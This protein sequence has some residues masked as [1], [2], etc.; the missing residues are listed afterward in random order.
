MNILITGGTGLIGSAL[1]D[2]WHLQHQLIVLTRSVAKATHLAQKVQLVASL[3][4]VDFNQLD[5]VI[6]LAGEP[7]VGKRWS[8]PQKRQLCD[9]RWLLT[10]QVVS[11]ISAAATPPK[12]LI[13][14]SAI[15]VYGRQQQ[16]VIDEHFDQYYPEFA[17]ELCQIWEQDALAAQSAQTRVC[18]LRTGIVLAKQAG[19]LK[20]MLPAFKAGLGGPIGDGKQYMSWIHID[21]MVRIIDMLLHQSDLQG[22]INATAPEPVTNAAFAQQ[23]AKVL[24]RPAILPMPAWLLKILL[25]EMADL[26]ITGQRVMPA[27]LLAAGFHFNYAALPQALTALLD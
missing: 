1:I 23:L 11:A 21:D 13:S 4:Q 27:K 26:L 17:S 6:N 12:V 15:G 7:I 14:G 16:Q 18:L 20:K 25:G 10:Q 24:H 8:A 2:R 9:S 22:A 3:K 19:A 5:A